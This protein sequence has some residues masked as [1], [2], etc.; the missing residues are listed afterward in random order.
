MIKKFGRC[1]L[2]A[3]ASAVLLAPVTPAFAQAHD[4][5]IIVQARKRDES[6]MDVPVI[7]SVLG[8]EKLDNYAVTGVAG[9][10]DKVTGLNYQGG[11]N[12]SGTLISMR[13]IGTS[14]NNPAVDQS[15]ALVTDGQQFTQGLAFQ[16]STFDMARVEVLKGP[17]ALFFGKAAPGGVIS[18]RT[19][20]P[21]DELEVILR[22]GYEVE[23]RKMVGEAIVSG[24]VTDT[25][26][27]RLATQYSDSDGFF[28]N[29]A[30]PT[31]GLFAFGA[32]P[33]KSRR[34]V[35]TKTFLLRATALWNPDDALS[36]RLKF[37]YVRQ[38]MQGWGG[39]G[40]ISSCPEGTA[41]H[42]PLPYNPVAGDDCKL[43]RNWPNPTFDQASF[44]DG[45]LRN[46]GVP[47]N[48]N[49]QIFGSLELNYLLSDSLNLTSLTSYYD[50]HQASLGETTVASN[51]GVVFALD[52]AWDR[53]DF[54]QEIR[55]ASN[56]A[57]PL[58]FMLGGFYQNGDLNYLFDL[59]VNKKIISL[60]VP[61]PTSLGQFNSAIGIETISMFGQLQYKITPQ[62][63]F[64]AGARWT[65]ETRDIVPTL[66]TGPS[67]SPAGSVIPILKN[68]IAPKNWSP[69][70]SLT[71]KPTENLTI[72]GNL[73][74]AYKS[75]SFDVGGTI[76][77]NTDISFGDERVRGAELGLKTRMLDGALRF[78]LAGY[79]QKFRGM[80]VKAGTI[81]TAGGIAVRTMNAAAAKIYGID[82][83]FN[84]APP[85]V[86]GLSIY[87]GVNWNHARYSNFPNAQCW[88]NQ[89]ASE[90]CNRL[91][92]AATGRFSAQDLS[93]APL[94]RAP[95]VTANLGFDLEK[96]VSSSMK[97]RFGSNVSYSSS[98]STSIT[99]YSRQAGFAKLGATLALASQDDRWTVEL[100][101]DNLTNKITTGACEVNA[102]ADSIVFARSA[103]RTGGTTR[104]PTGLPETLCFPN[105]GRSAFL[106]LTFKN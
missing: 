67:Y 106:R 5:E 19:A 91:L 33:P 58:N 88:F 81:V 6:I 21:K 29:T 105:P 86:D 36:A 34:L 24:P 18:I 77:P 15:V 17:Q 82:M 80:Q 46:D 90:G 56:N 96:L 104:G 7:A 48:K 44:G 9:I 61:L 14:S 26:G 100:I 60:G 83:D 35:D 62:L 92:N 27:L 25:L 39:T 89:L 99:N 74:Q 22:G 66:V 84:Y 40:E 10:A 65:K 68:H 87:G 47:F 37:N 69:E 76:S 12:A 32:L 20:D 78:N 101:G 95:N 23:A 79:Y 85:Q 54:T 13:G 55:L 28:R 53:S 71:Y 103:E 30:N 49:T 3:S 51:V 52:G 64:S 93:G 41:S 63:E 43:D 2:M 98:F 38:N 72:F 31:T 59:P 1:A 4:D 94:V 42:L 50:V 73:K 11:N 70:V 102:F 8:A 16:A 45:T 75:G 97:M 57:G